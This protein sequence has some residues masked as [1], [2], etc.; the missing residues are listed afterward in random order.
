[1]NILEGKKSSSVLLVKM[2]VNRYLPPFARA[3]LSSGRLICQRSTN[4]QYHNEG[5]LKKYSPKL[6]IGSLGSAS[7]ESKPAAEP[8]KDLPQKPYAP[9]KPKTEQKVIQP[10]AVETTPVSPDSQS[11]DDASEIFGDGRPFGDPSWY[12]RWHSY[13]P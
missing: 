5:V 13:F 3:N 1:M 2:P 9:P 10:E 7:E 8:Q 6:K 11:E 12:Q 4:K